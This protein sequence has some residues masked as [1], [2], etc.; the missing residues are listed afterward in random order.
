[1]L[2]GGVSWGFWGSVVARGEGGIGLGRI[3][4]EGDVL[5]V[6]MGQYGRVAEG[7]P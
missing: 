7:E 2:A 5:R 3:E 1:M 6:L 4:G